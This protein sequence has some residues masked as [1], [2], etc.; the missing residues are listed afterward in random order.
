[1]PS[2]AV[3]PLIGVLTTGQA[4]AVRAV[5]LILLTSQRAAAA[6]AQVAFA[7]LGLHKPI[8]HPTTIEQREHHAG[9]R[10]PAQHLEHA[11]GKSTVLQR[12]QDSHREERHQCSH[13][14]RPVGANRFEPVHA[15]I[16]NENAE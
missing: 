16:V 2:L 1:M 5:R 8:S 3:V 4:S 14:C 12:S 10:R 6:R 13:N 11:D 7:T 15:C 9:H